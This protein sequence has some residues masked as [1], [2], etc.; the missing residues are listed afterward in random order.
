MVLMVLVLEVLMIE[1]EISP[2]GETEKDPEKRILVEE[3]E[4]TILILEG[5]MIVRKILKEKE[6]VL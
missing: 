5:K 6:A 4:M 1:V 2:E 3:I